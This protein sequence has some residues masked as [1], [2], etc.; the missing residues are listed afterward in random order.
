MHNSMSF[1]FASR[2]FNIPSILPTCVSTYLPIYLPTYLLTIQPIYLSTCQPIYLLPYLPTY[3]CIYLPTYLSTTPPRYLPGYKM[4]AMYCA[5]NIEL[6]C[7]EKRFQTS[8]LILTSKINFCRLPFSKRRRINFVQ[9]TWCLARHPKSTLG[10]TINSQNRIFLLNKTF[11]LAVISITLATS[12]KT[13]ICMFLT[14]AKT[15][16]ELHSTDLAD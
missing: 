9:S 4:K 15:F 8:G 1:K 6:A 13:H 12:I 16:S 7:E 10:W 2:P 11:K 3:L 5:K 14:A